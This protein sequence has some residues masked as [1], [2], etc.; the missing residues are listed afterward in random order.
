M[1][2][3]KLPVCDVCKKPVDVMHSYN[4]LQSF[5]MVVEVECHGAIERVALSVDDLRNAEQLT[6]G[7][8]AFR[9]PKA[10]P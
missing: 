10:L 5:G 7:G 4:D 1:G 8:I 9:Q 3:V 2:E 6:T